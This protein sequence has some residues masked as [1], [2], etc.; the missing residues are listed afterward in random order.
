M[1]GEAPRASVSVP[2]AEE[3]EGTLAF[4]RGQSRAPRSPHLETCLGGLG[5]ESEV[6]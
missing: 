2:Q 6:C 1:A 5:G 4:L 3:A